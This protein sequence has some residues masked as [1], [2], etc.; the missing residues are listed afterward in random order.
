[1]P[2]AERPTITFSRSAQV[3]LPANAPFKLSEEPVP[4]MPFCPRRRD[5]GIVTGN[6]YVAGIPGTDAIL[7]GDYQS[8]PGRNAA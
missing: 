4:L 2:F 8:C 6:D 3:D 1:M 5:N 7:A